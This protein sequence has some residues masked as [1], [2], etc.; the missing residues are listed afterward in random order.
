M[1][2]GDSCPKGG[3]DGQSIYPLNL[4]I[5]GRYHLLL[6]GKFRRLPMKWTYNA[7]GLVPPLTWAEFILLVC[8]LFIFLLAGWVF[9]K[10]I[11]I[12]FEE[13]RGE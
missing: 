9:Y 8:V 1:F 6:F 2:E 7:L 3:G 4:Y 13:M 10:F 12:A 11:R 5:M